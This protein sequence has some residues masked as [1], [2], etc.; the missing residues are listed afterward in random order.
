MDTEAALAGFDDFVR[1]AMAAWKVPG[2]AIGIIKD[3]EVIFLSGFGRRDVDQNLPVTPHTL[4]P[5]AS[6][7]KAFTTMALA[8]AAGG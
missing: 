1:A 5:L 2:L 8:G 4:F 7:T 6:G 3:N